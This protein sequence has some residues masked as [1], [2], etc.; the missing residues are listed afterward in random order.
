MLE[1]EQA[2]QL[3]NDLDFIG[4]RAQATAVGLLQLCGELLKAG[5]LDDAAVG[6][7]KEAIQRDICVSNARSHAREE[8]ETT[9]RRRLDAVFPC[10]ETACAKPQVGPVG[11]LQ[12][13]LAGSQSAA[14]PS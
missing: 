4:L 8:F 6:R 14:R 9:L 3:H 11:A 2:R 13:D 7:I 10:A 1:R 12:A 5:V